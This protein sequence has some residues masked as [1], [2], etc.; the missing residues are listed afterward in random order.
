VKTMKTFNRCFIK[1]G[2]DPTRSSEAGDR[3]DASHARPSQTAMGKPLLHERIRGRPRA[4][5]PDMPVQ[6]E[7]VLY[8]VAC[9]QSEGQGRAGLRP[10][11]Q[12]WG[13]RQPDD[14][15]VTRPPPI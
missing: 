4:Y 3:R 7:K 6:G 14:E 10:R 13:S 9:A 2:R 8:K 15:T 1:G 5:T 11:P 12:P